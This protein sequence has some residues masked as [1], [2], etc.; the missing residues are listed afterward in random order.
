MLLTVFSSPTMDMGIMPWPPGVP[1][2]SLPDPDV[3]RCFQH[4]RVE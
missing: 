1:H 4:V 2:L 3:T